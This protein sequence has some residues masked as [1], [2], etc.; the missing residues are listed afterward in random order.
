MRKNATTGREADAGVAVVADAAAPIE[1]MK[2]E[3][4]SMRKSQRP[5]KPRMPWR[6]RSRLARKL[7]TKVARPPARPRS[8]NAAVAA[9]VADAA[10]DATRRERPNRARRSTTKHPPTT[11]QAVR[12]WTRSPT[13]MCPRGRRSSIRSIDRTGTGT[14]KRVL[15]CALA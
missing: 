3:R 7:T 6:R 14:G 5:R 4:P 10:P 12:K 2:I 15:S 8:R 9:D 11:M 13:G 1:P